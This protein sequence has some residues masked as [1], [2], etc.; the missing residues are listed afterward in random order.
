[1]ALRDLSKREKL[2]LQLVGKQPYLKNK[3][4]STI[5]GFKYAE[6]VSTLQKKLEKRGYLS[7]PFMFPDF[8]KIFRNRVSRV[9]AFVMFDKAYE[10]MRP[11]LEEIDCWTYFY[12][13]EEGVFRK[14]MIGF[15]N[16]DLQELKR[17]FDYLK[18]CGAIHYYHLFE[19]EGN[20]KLINPTFLVDN[21]ETPIEPDFN[22]LLDD[23]SVPDLRWGSF[24]GISL[25]HVAQILLMHLWNGRGK[26]NLRRIVRIE[27]DFR[28]RRRV[29]LKEMLRKERWEVKR[30]ELKAELKELKGDLPLR[31]FR[32]VYQLLI[33][34]D[35]LEKVYYIY[36][37][38][39]PRC[40]AFMLFLKCGSVETTKRTIFNFGKNVR[41]F[42]R[43]CMV[44]SVETEEWYGTIFAVGDPFLGGKLMTALDLY[45]EIV[46]RKLFPMRSYPSSKWKGQS[47]HLGGRYYNP[48]KQTL[49]FP[50][51]IFYEKVKQKL[52]D[53]H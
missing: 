33:D 20:W 28:K 8:G 52:E 49:H 10:E 35:I 16:T 22:H 41:I 31:E 48:E 11:V 47:I 50:Y 45:P 26:C 17:I 37:F 40:S 46:D 21:S 6:Y 38:P 43:V 39:R 29:E 24:A 4:L 23:I 1:M 7:G 2:L 5:I 3:D 14:Y 44:Q 42:T 18:E 27:K 25:N 32:E 9:F 12:P 53:I 34:R 15:M 30:K 51:K 19:L 13:V 36:P